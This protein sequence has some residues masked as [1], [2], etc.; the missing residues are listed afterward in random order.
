MNTYY[1]DLINGDEYSDGMDINN[2][3]KDYKNI[4]LNAGDCILFKRGTFVREPLYSRGGAPHGPITYGAYGE[5]KN[6]TFCGSIDVSDIENWIEIEPNLWECTHKLPSE[7]CNM[8]FNNGQMCGTL[9]WSKEE[10]EAQGDFWDNRFGTS[11][12]KL[13][14]P[15]QRVI[16]Y[17]ERNPGEFYKHIECVIYGFRKMGM[18][19]DNMIIEDIDFINS[20]VH[21]LAGGGTNIHIKR[22]GFYF[23]GGC[24]WNKDLKIRFGNG[25]EFFNYAHDVSVDDC[26]FNDIYDSG[27]TH[28]GDSFCEVPTNVKFDNN[29]FIKCGMAAYEGRDYVPVDSTFN[30]NICLDTGEG[31]SKLGEEMPRQSEIWPQPMGH[32]VF[33][34]RMEE[35]SKNGRLEISGNIFGNAKYGAT[36]YSIISKAAE[37]QIVFDNNTVCGTEYCVPIRF[38]GKNFNS[39]TE[40]SAST[41]SDT[42]LYNSEIDIHEIK[43]KWLKD[44]NR[45]AMYEF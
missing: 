2:P 4:S 17:S 42:N 41:E 11:E 37:E 5:G 30:N 1:I 35:K 8:V 9:K 18:L 15:K 34:W 36:V 13:K 40:F 20:G 6:P 44:H 23:I 38:F 29:M 19:A 27:V 32:H 24:V 16:I 22:C 28:Q 7:V 43:N 3:R 26:I 31:F 12:Q 14:Y 39:F 45:E 21:G 25:V 10:L 33:L